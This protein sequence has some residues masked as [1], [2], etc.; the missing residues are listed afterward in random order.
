MGDGLLVSEVVE[1]HFSWSTCIMSHEERFSLNKDRVEEDITFFFL[2]KIFQG[3]EISYC[4]GIKKSR[5][6]PGR[7]NLKPEW[8]QVK[9]QSYGEKKKLLNA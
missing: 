3:T 2:F 6:T 9:K 5:N 4:W 8:G 1:K 7:L